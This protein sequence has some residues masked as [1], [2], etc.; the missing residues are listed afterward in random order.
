VT[1]IPGGETL[2]SQ[3]RDGVIKLRD[4]WVLDPKEQDKLRFNPTV[5]TDVIY[6]STAVGRAGAFDRQEVEAVNKAVSPYSSAEPDI[7]EKRKERTA[8]PWCMDQ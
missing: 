3:A 2:T 6:L 5:P 8:Q 1:T 7:I 4:D